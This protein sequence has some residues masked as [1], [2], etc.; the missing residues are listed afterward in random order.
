MK[1]V[2]RI[3]SQMMR[4]MSS[5]A[6]ELRLIRRGRK[7][8]KKGR[9]PVLHYFHSVTDPFSQLTIQCIKTL[10]DQ[11][12]VDVHC[13]W[14]SAA[15]GDFVG[16]ASRFEGWALADA[17]DIAEPYGLVF[18]GP[19]I[20]P[21]VD[22]IPTLFKACAEASALDDFI[23]TALA[24]G[25]LMHGRAIR[26]DG[27][28]DS[29]IRAR[30]L[31]SCLEFARSAV[32][33]EGNRL[34]DQLGHFAS[35]LFYFE[36][37][38]YW[39]VDRLRVLESRLVEEGLGLGERGL[40]F[41]E[42]RASD[43]PDLSQSDVC[44]EYFPS[45]RSPYTAVGHER[46]LRLI[47]ATKVRVEVRVV[48]PMMMRGVPAP[49]RKGQLILSDSARE[50]R[51]FGAPLGRVVDPFGEPVRMAYAFLPGLR[52]EGLLMPFV[53]EYLRAAW[54]EGLDITR[55]KGLEQVLER[56]GAPLT[57]MPAP[58]AEWRREVEGNLGI[59]QGHDL[60]GVPSFRVTGGGLSPFA[61]WGQDRI[62]RVARELKARA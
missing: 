38:W 61:C 37:Q 58:E 23:D 10:R 43:L 5:E 16:D 31:E 32:V 44:L 20:Q 53:T 46:V 60:W 52:A 35:A 36:G 6:A 7:A 62:W 29:E 4:R 22:E 54:V 28:D 42:P 45:L 25:S 9:R 56:A 33:R 27:S 39:G 8:R 55:R 34:R 24:V 26:D 11:Y 21:S 48:M 18:P 30:L 17:R 3:R 1:L 47:E 50:G 12:D 41:P 59:M 15:K 57:L 2:T 51:F 40:A 14:V 19:F 13:H 49:A